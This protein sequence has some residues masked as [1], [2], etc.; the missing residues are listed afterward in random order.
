MITMNTMNTMNTMITINTV[1]R[2]GI[3]YGYPSLV[4]GANGNISLAVDTFKLYNQLI[5]GADLENVSHSDHTKTTSIINDPNM[6][7]VQIFGY[8]DSILSLS[9]FKK[10]VDLWKN[11]NVHGIFCDRF[12]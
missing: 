4:N 7:T 3:F 12:G 8:V 6:S 9:A 5:F 2:L 11:M 1:N 10:R